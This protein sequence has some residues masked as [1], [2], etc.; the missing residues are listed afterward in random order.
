MEAGGDNKLNVDQPPSPSSKEEHGS[1]HNNHL[2]AKSHATS[3]NEYLIKSLSSLSQQPILIPNDA[4]ISNSQ[5]D[6][7]SS[8]ND[9]IDTNIKSHDPIQEAEEGHQS[10]IGTS[11]IGTS[12]SSRNLEPSNQEHVHA[13][14]NATNSE[15]PNLEPS[16]H[17]IG[18]SSNGDIPISSIPNHE[19]SNQVSRQ[20]S[21]PNSP[22]ENIEHDIN[23]GPEIQNPQVQVMERPNESGAATSQYVFPSHVFA[24]NNTNTPEWSTASNESLFSIYMGNMSF[25]GE[26]ACFKSCELDKPC[27]IH[28]SDQPNASPNNQPLTPVNKFND[29]SQR[30]AELHEEGLK[31][32]EAKA[33]ETM[34][35]VIMESCL[36]TKNAVE[37]EDTKSKSQHEQDGSTKSYAFQT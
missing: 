26:L 32:T 30:I 8:T 6:T 4:T 21:T 9:K 1:T 20:S 12:P 7:N 15:T 18:E 34:R 29:I 3:N 14:I 28:M 24:R 31:V 19:H 2:E 22:R 5:D 27:D 37:K 11:Q 16:S 13:S 17:V 36:T 10:V 35:E 23:K 33:A 25:S